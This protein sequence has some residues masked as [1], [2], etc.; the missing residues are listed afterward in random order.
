MSLLRF[1]LSLALALAVTVAGADDRAPPGAGPEAVGSGSPGGSAGEDAAG[2]GTSSAARPTGA[3][4]VWR[5]LEGSDDIRRLR[6]FRESFPGTP[7]AAAAA[8]R[9]AAFGYGDPSDADAVGRAAL[10]LGVTPPGVIR[11]PVAKPSGERSAAA[12]RVPAPDLGPPPPHPH[13]LDDLAERAAEGDVGA[14]RRMAERLDEGGPIER[15]MPAVVYWLRRAAAAGDPHAQY[16]L[17]QLYLDGRGVD[18]DRSEAIR[19][20]EAAA[21]ARHVAAIGALGAALDR[22][23][24]ATDRAARLVHDAALHGDRATLLY[25]E[26][27]A[28]PALRDALARRLAAGGKAYPA[29]SAAVGEA[30]ARAAAR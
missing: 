11:V 26:T 27:D 14:M 13:S 16:A 18:R 28:S 17:A 5:H 9:L 15:D 8:E 24:G 7:E 3:A 22:A 30:L 25:V 12:A 21:A 2:E 1:P 29:A 4:I 23:G 10:G 20:L 6:R 19:W